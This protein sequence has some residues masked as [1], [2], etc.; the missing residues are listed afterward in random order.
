MQKKLQNVLP[1]YIILILDDCRRKPE[2][3]FLTMLFCC[4]INLWPVLNIQPSNPEGGIHQRL[5]DDGLPLRP[6]PATTVAGKPMSD[7]NF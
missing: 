3:R 6:A 7:H 4:D 1:I 5:S 2:S